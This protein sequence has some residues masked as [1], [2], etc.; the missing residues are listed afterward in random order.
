M[1]WANAFAGT[2]SGLMR[3]DPWWSLSPEAG[4]PHVSP[5][6]KTL[7]PERSVSQAL[8]SGGGWRKLVT[9]LAM[10]LLRA[11][12]ALH[13]DRVRHWLQVVRK[14]TARSAAE[15]VKFKPI[16]DRAFAK[17]VG[18]TVSGNRLSPRIKSTV[19]RLKPPSRPEPAGISEKDFRPE[20][21]VRWLRC[22]AFALTL[23]LHRK[24]SLSGVT[25]PDGYTSRP[26]LILP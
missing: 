16:R 6:R 26:H 1:R 11:S 20:T 23:F 3:P 10:S 5:A 25:G 21:L 8:E 13:V 19:A 7:P 14:N 12:T 17:L 4:L 22:G 18:P 9:A 2:A 15:V 24:A